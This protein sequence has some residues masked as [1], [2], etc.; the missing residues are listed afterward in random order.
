MLVA[1]M[2]DNEAQNWSVG[3]RFVQNIKI[4]AYH[5]GIKCP[6]Y[7]TAMFG[8]KPHVG[9]I[10]SS[11]PSK[12]TEMLPTEDDL[13]AVLNTPRDVSAESQVLITTGSYADE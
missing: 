1:W 5:S 12:V 3:L 6:I 11:L 4:S 9:L 13:N 8:T 2:M 10:S 7:Y